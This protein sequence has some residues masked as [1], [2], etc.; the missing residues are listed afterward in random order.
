MLAPKV[1]DLN[2]VLSGVD[3]MLRRLIGANIEPGTMAVAR[4]GRESVEIG[5]SH[6]GPIHLLLTDMGMPHLNGREVAERLD[7]VRPGIKTL[8]MSGYKE[9]SGNGDEGPYPEACFIQK[10]FRP[11]TLARKVRELLDG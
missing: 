9:D 2:R 5:T 8:S 4:D 3:M 7:K 1:V 11:E 10:P 6:E